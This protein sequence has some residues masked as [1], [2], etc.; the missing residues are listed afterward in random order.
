MALH[1][2]LALP[3]FRAVRPRSCAWCRRPLSG[4]ATEGTSALALD[5]G[6]AT[7]EVL[8]C[9]RH[10]EPTRR[11]FTFLDRAR[12]PLRLGIGVPLLAL[13]AALA[14][15][16]L[17]APR[18]LAPATEAFRLLIGITVH[19]AAAGGLL[20]TPATRARAAFPVHNFYLLGIRAILWIFRIVGIWWIVAA[21]RYWL[22]AAGF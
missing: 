13:L 12:W 17:G 5:V 10:V 20:V 21:G 19:V 15:A 7:L 3:Y 8:A 4:T 9:P 2:R 22:A 11:F 14:D 18:F 6:D 1:R 16:A